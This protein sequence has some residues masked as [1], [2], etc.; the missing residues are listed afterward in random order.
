[1]KAVYGVS[2]AA[3]FLGVSKSKLATWSERTGVG[4]RSE[5]GSYTYDDNDMRA[6]EL[7]RSLREEDRSFDT[8]VRRIRPLGETPA[9]E[10]DGHPTDTSSLVEQVTAAVAAA[11]R[12]DLRMGEKY[13][14]AMQRLCDLQWEV[15]Q[16]HEERHHL[17][18]EHQRQ[19]ASLRTE[20][21]ALMDEL[22][23]E[24]TKPWWRK[25]FDAR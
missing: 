18:S 7:I 10:A 21:D 9:A 23:A 24:R 6:L 12:S 15:R 4:Q 20:I 25:L 17:L 14:Q 13:A 5:A 11:V 1:M 3:R 2:D 16:L 8:I 19:T 22:I